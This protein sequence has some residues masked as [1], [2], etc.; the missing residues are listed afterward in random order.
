MCY[1]K[2]AATNRKP[3]AKAKSITNKPVLKNAGKTTKPGEKKY[4]S[5]VSIGQNLKLKPTK[6]IASKKP[7]QT[8]KTTAK[9]AAPSKSAK[10]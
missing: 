10:T 9:K 4:K 3:I 1:M 8:V 6:K 7:V 2:H 5:I